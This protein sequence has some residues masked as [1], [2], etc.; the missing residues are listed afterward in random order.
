[1]GLVDCESLQRMPYKMPHW[2]SDHNDWWWQKQQQALIRKGTSFPN[3]KKRA[4]REAIRS[5]SNFD[6]N[7]IH[8][9][10][11]GKDAGGFCRVDGFLRT[12]EIYPFYELTAAAIDLR[13]LRNQQLIALGLASDSELGSNG[14]KIQQASNALLEYLD[15]L[16]ME[17][18]WELVLLPV[19]ENSLD[20]LLAQEI[21]LLVAGALGCGA[22]KWSPEVVARVFVLA[23]LKGIP[24]DVSDSHVLPQLD[25]DPVAPQLCEPSKRIL[26]QI[27]P[28]EKQEKLS[29]HLKEL[30]KQHEAALNVQI[31]EKIALMVTKGKEKTVAGCSWIS[32]TRLNKFRHIQFAIIDGNRIPFDSAMKRH[33]SEYVGQIDD[34]A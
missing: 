28:Q 24:A 11:L 30:R 20:S 14:R 6:E 21:D 1:M 8:P 33:L 31:D 13:P 7:L 12:D 25:S 27:D 4:L 15:I 2:S 32:S 9:I 19:I 16:H 26:L 23:L 10:G 18:M 22:F 34:Q 5:E 17:Q 29:V 3:D